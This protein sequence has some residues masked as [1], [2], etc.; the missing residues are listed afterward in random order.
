MILAGVILLY[1]LLARF[2]ICKIRWSDKK[3]KRIFKERDVPIELYNE[4]TG[5]RT[6]HY[7]ITGSDDHPTL[8]FIHG[9]PASWFRF[10]KLML[11]EEM[12][13]KFRMLAIDRPGLG[14]SDFG[15]ALPLQEQCK[16]LLPVIKKSKGNKPLYLCGHSY[17]GA[18]VSQL[19]ADAPGLVDQ[20]IILAGAI[21]PSQ[22][23]KDAAWR[24]ILDVP[25]SWFLP[26]AYRTMNTELTW[27]KN[28][29]ELLAKDL[30]KIEDHV[31]FIHGDKDKLVP[32]SNTAYGKKMMTNS[33]SLEIITLKGAKHQLPIDN[34]QELKPVLL[35]LGAHTTNY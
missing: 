32:F 12:R 17:G 19:A 30:Y 29:L 23:K 15:K 10:E 24:M 35:G 27:F 2:V 31:L 18:V 13:K 1:L 11:D 34:W 16:L 33:A 7:A 22:E 14:Y 9:T 5:D 20:L 28:D 8:V 6:I 3:S 25:L 26:G 4:K 21:D